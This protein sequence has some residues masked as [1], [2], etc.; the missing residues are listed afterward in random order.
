MCGIVGQVRSSGERV[1]RDLIERMCA[2]QAHRGPDSRGVHIG[3]GVGLGIQRLRI[4]DLAT[5]DQPIY[6]E[7]RSV[8]VVLN[9][10]IYN[11]RELR[12]GLERRGHRFATHSDT[13]VI[14]H[15][16]EE[17]GVGCV[18]SLHGMFAFAVWDAK[19]RQLLV[20][21][22]RV[23]K[24]PLFY[25]ERSGALS[26]ASELTALMQDSEI[27]G[28]ADHQAVDAYLAYGYVPAPLSAFGAV[29][30]LPPGHILVQRDGET[31]LERYWRL[32][33]ANKR[34]FTDVREL[35]DE[36]R[37][38]I[39]Q[40]VRKR[41]IADVPVGAF[42][43]GGID[44]SAVVAAMA[45]TSS[46]PIKT[47]SIGFDD[48]RHNELPR[49][50]RI[51]QEFAT[52]HHEFVVQPDAVELLP[53][54]VRHYGEPFADHSAMACFYLAEMASQHVTVALNG[55]GGDES[56]AG[57]QRY[58]SNLFLHRLDRLPAAARRA[59][60]AAAAR[61]R[62]NGTRHALSSRLRR[63]ATASA[64]DPRDR[65]ITQLSVFSAEER[66][67]LR[68]PGYAAFLGPSSADEVI[69]EPWR[70]ASGPELL[71]QLLEVDVTA[72]LPGDLLAKIDIAT[73]A[74]SL[75]ARSPLLD[76]EFMEFAAALEP[77]HKVRG[78][79]RKVAF[80]DA[81][82][83]W[84]P[85]EVLDGPKRGFELP[86]AS[87]FRGD[88]SGF[89]REVLLD[90]VATDRGLFEPSGVQSLLD[91]HVAGTEDN[92]RKIWAL[93]QLELWYR[94]VLEQPREPA[95]AAG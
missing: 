15:L 93:L 90:P 38:E 25:S 88:L 37:H 92:G 63:L 39:R 41:M 32:D 75:E 28:D 74:Y 47:F 22:D 43:S 36:I 76:H 20:A 11:Y 57:Y 17:E 44:S 3:P 73:M 16:Y 48:E 78:M 84:I 14:V 91:R 31:T 64:R 42:L 79:E 21:R 23:G 51:A 87:W 46:E 59:L 30:K 94:H 71:D 40:A 72:Y 66:R 95:M 62:P 58:T 45:E 19:R 18:S 5:G 34:K 33:Y 61:M 13:E 80:R 7:D 70:E 55:D 81:L 35:H 52:D 29:R 77:R 56:F 83:G 54:I 9:G 69:L 85:D 8:I 26:F 53:K 2:A 24:K 86:L 60:A 50:R 1:N 12:E 4:I 27:P 65:Y 67:S 82:R 49:A 68:T 89:A 10:E 6:N